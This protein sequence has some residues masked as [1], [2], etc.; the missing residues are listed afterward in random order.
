VAVDDA[1]ST[2]EDAAAVVPVLAND[3][4]PDGDPLTVIAAGPAAHGT[5]TTDG[6]TI[7]YAPN[8]DFFGADSLT[9]TISD[10]AGYTA[11]AQVNITVTPID[12]P[13]VAVDD[14]VSTAEDAALTLPVLANDSDPD[15]DPLTVTAAGPAAHGTVTTDGVTVAYAPNT[16]FFGADSFSYTI[17]DGAGH[18]AT[19]R[20]N[21]TVTKAV[22]V[23]Y[24][25]FIASGGS[26]DER[27]GGHQPE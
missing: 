5:V 17:S 19:A 6:V 14:A 9:Y 22:S 1:V 25:P 26:A 20:A 7:A 8:T 11:T 12:D 18:T 13:P 10:G 16:D 3:T 4:D 21:I 2:A 15:G 27:S 24:L 23:L